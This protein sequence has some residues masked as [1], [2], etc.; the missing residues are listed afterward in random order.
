MLRRP[1]LAAAAA[2]ALLIAPRGE[3]AQ[4]LQQVVGEFGLLGSWARDCSKP[5]SPQTPRILYAATSDGG[6][7]RELVEGSAPGGTGT[8]FVAASRLA[9][10]Q[11]EV[12]YPYQDRTVHLVLE[13]RD[14]KH[15]GLRSWI[16]G[17]APIMED[18]VVLAN[19]RHAPWLEKCKE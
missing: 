13:M 16:D 7:R 8:A 5:A 9:P 11:L 18:G 1:L 2:L 15:R 19:N 17:G 14:G 3:A 10:D 4:N 12:D 6:V